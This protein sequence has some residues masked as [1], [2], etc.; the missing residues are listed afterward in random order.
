MPKRSRTEDQ[1]KSMPKA[2]PVPVPAADSKKKVVRQL[3]KEGKGIV[4]KKR[5]N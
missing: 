5:T 3:I 1:A 4:H 2:V